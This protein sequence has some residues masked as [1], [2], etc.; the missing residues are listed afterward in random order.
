MSYSTAA[1]GAKAITEHDPC[2]K[3]PVVSD[4]PA[5]AQQEFAL[6]QN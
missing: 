1:A 5:K 3:V 2:D 6:P 4:L